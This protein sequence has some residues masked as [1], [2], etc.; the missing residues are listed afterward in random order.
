VARDDDTL[1]PPRTPVEEL[2]TGIW[3]QVLGVETISI[4]DNFFERG[5]DSILSIQ[6]VARANQAGLRL[7]TQQIFQHQTIAAL[8]EVVATETTV[9]AEQGVVTGDVPLTPIQAWFFDQ[10]LPQ[11]HHFNQA[12]LLTVAPPPGDK[13]ET[14]P[15][16]DAF[17]ATIRSHH[18]AL[19]LRYQQ[20]PDGWQQ[21]NAAADNGSPFSE[22]DLS[23][24]PDQTR[25]TAL[26]AAAAALQASLSLSHGP[27]FRC[28][29][30]HY[31][32]SLPDRL[33]V[34]IHHLAVDG[35]SWR[36]LFD[37]LQTA[38]QQA[39]AG[40]PLRLPSKTTAYRT[41]SQRLITYAQSDAVGA[42]ADYWLAVPDTTP[43]PTD[44]P[45]GDNDAAST[46]TVTV[47]LSA[48]ETEALLQEV[49]QV[50]NTHI[51]DALLA[52]L[53]VVLTDWA[54]NQP[55][56]IALEGHGRQELLPDV[57]LSRTVGWF[58]TI[59][60]LPL[61]PPASSHPGHLLRT[62]KEQLRRI[63]HHGFHYGLLRYLSHDPAIRR[64]LQAQP[65]PQVSFNY[66]GQFDQLLPPDGPF[67]AAPESSGPSLNP[68]GER[69][70]VLEINGHTASGCLQLTWIY[71]K[72]VHRQKT[73][74]SLA[75]DYV[76]ALQAIIAHCR[77]SETGGYTPSDFPEMTLNQETLDA[78][79]AK[80][81]ESIEDK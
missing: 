24:L 32:P 31:G 37:D 4:H 39:A 14:A 58:T 62:V 22:I 34:I 74:A 46:A 80:Y 45:E 36:I 17:V 13:V 5:G 69:P 50:Y 3:C 2:L 6:I 60:P 73:I 42:E 76:A 29:Y 67:A 15:F 33:L 79:L 48:R 35:V 53:S 9:T 30:F 78:I 16:L 72:S 70:Y 38:Y 63:P 43:L 75:E 44:F 51:N 57:D 81:G 7:S 27:L 19:R 40:H 11:R 77:S 20:H 47:S 41:W 10:K 52:A 65:L 64:A 55:V 23:L 18:D 56:T 59:Y 71:S 49:P 21:H 61:E 26:E 54:G 12:V 28:A 1:V 25:S 68:E 8:A 66:L